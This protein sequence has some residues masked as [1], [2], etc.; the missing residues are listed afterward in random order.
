M[1]R[2]VFL[3]GTASDISTGGEYN[4]KLVTNV[5]G[6]AGTQSVSVP[7][8]TTLNG[9]ARTQI[10]FPGARGRISNY[11]VTVEVTTGSGAVTLTPEIHRL[12][13][14]N[15][16]VSSFTGFAGQTA[17]AGTL[18][19]TATNVDLG[20]FS[21]TSRIE[22]QFNYTNNNAHGGA[23]TVVIATNSTTAL[24]APQWGTRA[25]VVPV[26]LP[27]DF[28]ISAQSSNENWEID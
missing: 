20:T 14:A 16:R 5:V 23:Q 19:F 4:L 28:A 21:A 26:G 22:I 13:S 1:A 25:T 8:N 12:N 7:A 3:S 6:A 15:T 17:N 18:T 11:T 2:R 10:I 24:F 27:S 9:F